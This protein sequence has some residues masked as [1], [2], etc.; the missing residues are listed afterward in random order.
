MST[1]LPGLPNK[2]TKPTSNILELV[3]HN[4]NTSH[5]RPRLASHPPS[6]TLVYPYPHRTL[7]TSKENHIN[8]NA[9]NQE[10]TINK[11]K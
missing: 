6:T 11:I 1:I 9:I 10:N 4:L 5:G 7:S 2:N 8:N 3:Q